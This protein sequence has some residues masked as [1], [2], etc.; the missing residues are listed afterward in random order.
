MKMKVVHKMNEYFVNSAQLISTTESNLTCAH[1]EFDKEAYTQF[2]L[3]D[4][5]VVNALREINC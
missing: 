2:F 1:K 5:L 3:Q 4:L